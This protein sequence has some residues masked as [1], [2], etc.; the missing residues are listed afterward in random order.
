MSLGHRNSR[1]PGSGQGLLLSSAT[2]TPER[3]KPRPYLADMA[4]AATVPDALIMSDP[5]PTPW[6]AAW[7]DLP[8]AP[9][10][11]RRTPPIGQPSSSGNRVGVMLIDH[12]LPSSPWRKSPKLPALP[13][14]ELEVS[15][16]GA[17][18]SRLFRTLPAVRAT[19][20]TGIRTRA[21]RTNSCRWDYVVPPGRRTRRGRAPS[22]GTPAP[23]RAD[24]HRGRRARGNSTS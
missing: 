16:H 18:A 3:H 10:R 6:C 17:S 5:G 12:P 1:G 19:S 24:A 7:P 4:P 21:P 8:A 14:H 9:C 15:V 2:S 11:S 20:T 13:G 23:R 22:G